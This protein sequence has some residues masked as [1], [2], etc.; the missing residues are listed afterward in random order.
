MA[1]LF[2][3]AVAAVLFAGCGGGNHTSALPAVQSPAGSLSAAQMNSLFPAS[4]SPASFKVAAMPLQQGPAASTMSV[5]P[6]GAMPETIGGLAWSQVPGAASR[7]AVGPDGS[8][9]ALSTAPAG[10]NK[11]LYHYV[12]GTWSN[13]PGLAASIAVAPNG[14]LYAVNSSSGGVFAYNGSSWSALGGGA[15]WVTTGADGSVYVLSNGNIVS[16]NSAIWKYSGGV[17]TQ[18]PGI[19]SQLAGSFDANTYAISGVGT[20]APNGFFVINAAGAVYYYSSTSGYV[21]F[22]G[23]ASNVAPTGGGV[24]VLGYP[25]SAGGEEVYYFDYVTAGWTAEPGSGVTVAAGPGSGTYGTQLYV[26]SSS[27]AIYTTAV[28]SGGLNGPNFGPGPGWG[29]TDLA[30]TFKFPVQAGYDGTGTTVAIVMDSNVLQSDFNAYNTY[31]DT[32]GAARKVGVEDIDGGGGLTS[33]GQTEATLDVETVGGLAPGANVVIYAMPDLSNQSIDDALDQIISDG[34]AKIASMSF[35]GCESTFSQTTQAPIFQTGVNAGIT[36]VA[37]SGDQGNEC[38]TGGTPEYQ[39]GAN[40]PASDPNVTG[41]GGN[42]TSNTLANPVAWND[43]LCGSGQCAT[44]GGVSA[45]FG[46]P[47]YQSGVSGVASTSF[48]NVPD[49]ALPSVYDSV[50]ENGSWILIAGTSWSA[51]ASA[52]MLAEISEYCRSSLGNANPLLYSAFASAKATDYIDVTSGN[53]QF[54]GTSPYYTAGVGYDNTTGLGLPLG[55]PL[56]QTLCPN[57]TLVAIAHRAVASAQ[58]VQRAAAAYS[59]DVRPAA[60][61]LVDLG[62]RTA[63]ATTRIQIV[64]QPSNSLAADESHVLATLRD[65]GLTIVKTFPNHLVVDA[66]GPSSAIERLF[67]TQ[68]D[69]FTQP[70]HGTRYAAARTATIPASLAPYLSGVLLDDVVAFAHPSGLKP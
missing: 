12:N 3:V 57:R 42:E 66:E 27:T 22:P 1:R 41:V 35:G 24:F 36:F 56:T 55:T 21:K 23:A 65:A 40:Y 26:V 45:L 16:G 70:G 37:S 30:N 54:D 44:G 33:D 6:Q 52:A 53:N 60:R 2:S 9:W 17:W 29:P 61:G 18:Q 38:F 51:P 39:V 48:R 25:S 19:G 34:R 13:V 7:L 59:V 68:I 15:D 47:S 50:Y 63:S 62:N 8:L 69:D 20:V 43:D 58:T 4:V 31:F 14:T 64:L 67:G 46:L 10:S 5:K 32:P 11:Y 28:P 49:I